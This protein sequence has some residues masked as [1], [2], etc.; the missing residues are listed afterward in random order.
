M[1]RS[2]QQ[3]GH[4]ERRHRYLVDTTV[5]LLRHAN[6]PNQ[7]WDYWVLTACYF[8]NRNPTPLLDR[9]SSMET[10]LGRSLEYK[11]LRI[12]DSSCYLCLRAYRSNKL[13]AKSKLCII[14]GYSMAQDCY[15]FLEPAS[16][17]FF[18]SRDVLFNEGD[19]SLNKDIFGNR[20]DISNPNCYIGE[21][22][23]QTE[24]DSMSVKEIGSTELG[25]PP[26]VDPTIDISNRN[27][28]EM[29]LGVLISEPTPDLVIIEAESLVV[30]GKT[31][32]DLH[33]AEEEESFGDYEIE[34]SSEEQIE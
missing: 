11:N 18:A 7:F 4:V 30:F 1:P 6:L 28:E 25:C 27:N 23:N 5:A 2:H 20:D 26:T 29:D 13:K 22:T 8:Y 32:N 10:L 17:I 33:Y 3:M 14:V 9:K 12:L 21:G 34:R 15:L 19:F 31:V 24:L 16:Q